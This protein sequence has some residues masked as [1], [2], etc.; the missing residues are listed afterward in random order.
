MTESGGDCCN[1][2]EHLAKR[3]PWSFNRSIRISPDTLDLKP[4]GWGI[5]MQKMT[6]GG[7]ATMKGQGWLICRYCPFCGTKLDRDGLP[8]QDETAD[9]ARGPQADAGGIVKQAEGSENFLGGDKKP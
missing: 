5:R 7:R 6:A 2:F 1:G 4:A 3:F 9:P 8:A